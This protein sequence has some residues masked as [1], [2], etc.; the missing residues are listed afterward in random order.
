MDKKTI[1]DLLPN[2]N[3]ITSTIT[4][5]KKRVLP[6]LGIRDWGKGVPVIMMAPKLVAA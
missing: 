2:S 3:R 5:I 1:S 6:A 4:A